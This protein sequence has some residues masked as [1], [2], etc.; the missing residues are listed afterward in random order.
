MFHLVAKKV[1]KKEKCRLEFWIKGFF[2]QIREI[3][4]GF[5]DCLGNEAKRKREMFPTFKM[6]KFQIWEI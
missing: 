2:S 1:D 3:L 6:K 4:D 5:W